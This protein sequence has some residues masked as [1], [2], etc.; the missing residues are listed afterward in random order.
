MN[1]NTC[2]YCLNYEYDD[3]TEMYYCQNSLD[4]DEMAKYI[5]NS[6]YNCPYFHINNEY[7]IVKKQ[8]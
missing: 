6:Y 7:E 3:F 4:E 2:E 5:S 1:N 8:N